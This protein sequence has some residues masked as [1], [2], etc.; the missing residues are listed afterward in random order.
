MEGHGNGPI[1]ILHPNAPGATNYLSVY[2]RCHLDLAPLNVAASTVTT[3]PL[4]LF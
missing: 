4:L 1:D 2:L 3:V